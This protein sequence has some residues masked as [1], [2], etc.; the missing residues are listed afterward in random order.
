MTAAHPS[1][2]GHAPVLLEEVLRALRPAPGETVAD[3]TAG[4]GGHASAMARAVGPT[5]RVVLFDLD[6]D[7]LAFAAERVRAEGVPVEAVHA[8][9]ATAELELAR[10]GVRADAVLADLGFASN[11]MDNPARGFSFQGEGPLDMRLDPT[12]GETAAALLARLDERAIADAIFQ[13]GEDPFA[14]RIARSIVARR[15]RGQLAT[16]A[17]LSAAVR[18][19]Y[20]S[21]AHH[22][23]MHPA[24]RTFMALRI[25]VNDELGALGAL[26]ASVARGAQAAAAAAAGSAVGG[27]NAAGAASGR[28]TPIGWLSRGA[29]VGIISFHSLE[30]R[31]VKH[32]FADLDRDGLA[33]RLTRKP[34]EAGEAES[35]VNPR[36]RSAKFRAVQIGA[37][38][39]SDR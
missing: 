13:W 10:R 7:N 1:D 27:A 26:L 34:V 16:T 37:Q 5:G 6:P 11:Q 4:R 33:H 31:M 15:G 17:D 39:P 18:E 28:A 22:S 20:G 19:A 9:F 2:P 30:D 29:R 36:A 21:R 12:R 23:R 38:S 35:R 32:A 24:T 14:R 3:L 25:L 8:S